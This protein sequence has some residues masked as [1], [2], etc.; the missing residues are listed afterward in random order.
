MQ[1][2]TV[3]TLIISAGNQVYDV[4]LGSDQGFK[5]S[6]YY[7]MTLLWIRM[8]PFPDA[9]LLYELHQGSPQYGGDKLISLLPFGLPFLILL[10]SITKAKELIWLQNN[11][12]SAGEG[13]KSNM[14]KVQTL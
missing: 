6:F 10:F 13:E 2:I 11:P 4:T 3:E 1:I 7:G 12:Q 5:N 9:V 8:A 14:S